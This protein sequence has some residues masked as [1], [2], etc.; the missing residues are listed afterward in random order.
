MIQM[1]YEDVI[2]KIKEKSGLSD[3]EIES[4]I[5]N[6]LEQLSGLISKE[7]AAHIIANELGIKL[8]EQVSGRLQIKNILAGMRDVEA[9]GKVTNVFE[10]REFM[11]E[12]SIGHVG[13]FII[14]D[15]TGTI[16]VV[17]WGDKAQA[18]NDIKEGDI[19]KVVSAYVRENN[20]RK[21]IHLNDRSKLL[22]NPPDEKV[23][24]VKAGAAAPEATRKEINSLTESDQNVEILGTIVQVFEPRFFEV[25]PQCKRRAMPK[26]GKFFCNQHNEVLPEYSYVFN[27]SLDDGTGNIR[28]GLF[29]EQAAKLIGKTNEEMLKY[30][31]NPQEFDQ[32]KNDLLGNIVKIKGR[33]R[34]NEMFGRLEFTAQQ[35]DP[36]PDPQKEIQRLKEQQNS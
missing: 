24:E 18:I 21:E 25:C 23:G 6:K 16:R 8:F 30:R 12:E 13:S 34:K 10:I 32:V 5:T 11:R 2:A 20:G 26:E 4:K 22:L 14:G 3:S 1:P 15:E 9:V 7:G 35:V 19:V 28:C 29:R 17:C 31:E 27:V 33:I 36:N